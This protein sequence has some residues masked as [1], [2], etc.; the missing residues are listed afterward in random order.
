MKRLL[1]YMLLLGVTVLW[2]NLEDRSPFV[3]YD[4]KR[5]PGGAAAP[6]GAPEFRGVLDMGVQ[7][8]KFSIYDTAAKR[9]TWVA[10]MDNE[11]PYYVENYDA[12]RKLVDITFGGRRMELPLKKASDTMIPVNASSRGKKVTAESKGAKSELK[13]APEAPAEE[14]DPEKRKEMA[15]KV[16]DAFRKYVKERKEARE[17]GEE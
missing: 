2:G 11:A 3:P 7:G 4:Y 9:S 16:F 10:M 15:K 17:G 13:T 8:M 1:T 12:E 14:L 5:G 6:K